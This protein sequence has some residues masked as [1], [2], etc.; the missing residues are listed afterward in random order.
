MGLPSRRKWTAMFGLILFAFMVTGVG[1]G[2]GS[3]SAPSNPGTP[4]GNY[5]V[6]VTAVSGSITRTLNVSVT[7]Q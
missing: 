6:V 4:A 3:S 2:G 1:C 5:T 7:V